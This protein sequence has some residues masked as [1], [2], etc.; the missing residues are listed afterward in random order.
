M[1]KFDKEAYDKLLEMQ[2]RD[3]I[4]TQYCKN[5]DIHL[6][7]IPFWDQLY[8]EDLLF[9]GLVKYGALIEE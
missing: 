3:A 1:K 8:I 7:R 2:E 6:I 4:K 9:D 5:N